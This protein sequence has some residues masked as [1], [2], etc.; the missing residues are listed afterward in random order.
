M[1]CQQGKAVNAILQ[2]ALGKTLR[3]DLLDSAYCVC[4]VILTCARRTQ[5]HK[6]HILISA[7]CLSQSLKEMKERKIV[8][9]MRGK[10]ESKYRR[11]LQMKN[12]GTQEE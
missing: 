12:L 8:Q 2:G 5:A 9:D 10:I 1:Y 4:G 6:F 7:C 3:A 11:K